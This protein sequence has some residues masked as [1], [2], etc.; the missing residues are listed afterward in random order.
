MERR[1]ESV[2]AAVADSRLAGLPPPS[3]REK[4]IMDAYIRGEIESRDLVARIVELVEVLRHEMLPPREALTDEAAGG[5]RKFAS[6]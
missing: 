3:G 4:A 1:R 2:R 5:E 6:R